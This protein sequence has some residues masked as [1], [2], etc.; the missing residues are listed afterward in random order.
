LAQALV[1]AFRPPMGTPHPIEE[2]VLVPGSKGLYEITV[3]SKLVYSKKQ[4]GKHISDTDAI[5]LIRAAS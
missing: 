4:T 1:A 2:I 5:K 3:D